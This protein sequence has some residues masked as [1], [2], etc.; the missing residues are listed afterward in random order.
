MFKLDYDIS[1]SEE[2]RYKELSKSLYEYIYID[3]EGDYSAATFSFRKNI[4]NE[5]IYSR[6][7][8][9]GTVYGVSHTSLVAI[10]GEFKGVESMIIRPFLTQY[11][12]IAILALVQ[13]ASILRFQRQSSGNLKN[14]DIQDL[15]KRYINYRNQ[16]HFFE[17]SSQEQGI[18][19]Y[20]LIRKQLY[21][22]KEIESLEKNLE[23]LYEKSNVDMSNKIGAVGIFIA[24]ISLIG[25]LFDLIA[26]FRQYGC[27]SIF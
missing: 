2:E 14:K 3:K 19:L 22:E 5:S 21:I 18:E 20:E 12:E 11:V 10:T 24:A 4:L 15:Q 7:S 6:W 8:E 25:T 26:Y 17:V 13:R 27:G 16:L 23:I 1:A 9:Y